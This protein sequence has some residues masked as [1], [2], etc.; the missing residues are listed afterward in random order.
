[1]AILQL[2][3]K[4]AKNPSHRIN[5]ADLLINE[6]DAIRDAFR[7]NNAQLLKSQFNDN[8]EIVAHRSQIVH[9]TNS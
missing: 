5:L 7:T 3:E 6:S 9:V 8:A 1:M 2:L 4:M